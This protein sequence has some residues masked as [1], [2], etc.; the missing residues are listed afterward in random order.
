MPYCPVPAAA[1][2]DGTAATVARMLRSD[3][4]LGPATA[5]VLAIMVEA[6]YAQLATLRT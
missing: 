2:A 1:P 6:T 3:S 4:R 5:N